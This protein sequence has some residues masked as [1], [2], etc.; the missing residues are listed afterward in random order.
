MA[1]PSPTVSK[2]SPYPTGSF[3]EPISSF[4]RE[5]SSSIE[6]DESAVGTM[7]LPCLAGVIGNSSTI[8]VTP[9]YAEPAILWGVLIGDSGSRKTPAFKAVA[10]GIEEEEHRLSREHQE[11]MQQFNASHAEREKP[12]VRHEV[13]CSDVT[14]EALAPVLE[15]NERGVILLREELAQW[16][17]GMNQYKKGGADESAWCEMFGASPI[18]VNRKT[19]ESKIIYVPRAAVSVAGTIT[20][21]TMRARLGQANWENGL[22][23]RLLMAMPEDRARKECGTPIAETAHDMRDVF[24]ALYSLPLIH[25]DEGRIK[26][27]EYTFSAEAKKVRRNFFAEMEKRRVAAEDGSA[28]AILSK[29][30]GIQARIAL[31]LHLAAIATGYRTRASKT[32]IGLDTAA[33]AVALANWYADENLRICG[34]LGEDE[35]EKVLRLVLEWIIKQGRPVTARDI[36]RGP[37][38]LRKNG[39]TILW[40]LTTLARRKKLQVRQEKAKNGVVVDHYSV[41]PFAE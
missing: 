23:P 26:P 35:E 15:K 38:F 5:T 14:I 37:A 41:T 1:S 20:P 19:G 16:L 30:Q 25:D 7:I 33:A 29:L 12:P 40:A 39:G 8:R 21:G 34:V 28:K 11:D 24:S 31:V 6:V 18:K 22:A 3:P 9:Q 17:G 4:I 36:E 2:S 32:Q 13:Y 10:A 27:C